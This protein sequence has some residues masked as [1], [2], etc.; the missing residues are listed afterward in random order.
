MHSVLGDSDVCGLGYGA[1]MQKCTEQGRVSML[2]VK[3]TTETVGANIQG[4]EGF[5]EA[6]DASERLRVTQSHAFLLNS[7]VWTRIISSFSSLFPN[8]HY[9]PSQ[10]SIGLETLL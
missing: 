4:G 3:G 7:F 6:K 5:L 1:Y 2:G 10:R 9:L 8:P